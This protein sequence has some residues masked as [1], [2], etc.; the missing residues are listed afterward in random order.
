MKNVEFR[1]NE[2][3]TQVELYVDNTFAGFCSFDDANGGFARMGKI[4]I[5]EDYQGK[6]FYRQLLVN[7]CNMFDLQGFFSHERNETSN[8]IYERW[9]GEELE[10]DQ[11]VDVWCDGEHLDF[12]VAEEA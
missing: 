6:G 2:A 9:T 10:E 11:Q 1:K 12:M 7:M 4:E 3:E 8:A 5:F